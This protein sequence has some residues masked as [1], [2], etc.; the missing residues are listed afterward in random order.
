MQESK[1][2]SEAIGDAIPGIL[3]E[4]QNKEVAGGGVWKSMKDRDLA[5]EDKRES[6]RIG[7]TYTRENS[8]VRL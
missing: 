4:Y 5:R 1:T 7:L 8:T 3:Y 6:I 2:L